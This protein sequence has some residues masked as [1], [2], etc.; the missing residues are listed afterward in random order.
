MLSSLRSRLWLSY[1]IVILMAVFGI[2]GPVLSSLSHS[3]LFY[4]QLV[5]HLRISQ[6]NLYTR[7][8]AENSLDMGRI[9]KII[10]DQ[11]R[12]DGFRYLLLGKDGKIIL[13]S[14]QGVFSPIPSFQTPIQET[15][16][17][18]IY[19]N[20]LTD[21]EHKPWMYVIQPIN[22]QLFFV[23]ASRQPVLEIRSLLRDEIVQP[24]V[25]GGIVALFFAF[26]LALFMSSWIGS[27]LRRLSDG[28]RQIE[29]GSYPV[30]EKEGPREIQKL[31]ESFNQMSR[32]VQQTEE[33]QK[34]FLANVSHEL[35]TP[36][37]SI[38][39]FAQSILDGAASTPQE[40]MQAASVI[41]DES[42][43][44]HRLVIDLLT[45]SRLEEGTVGMHTGPVN[46]SMIMDQLDEKL[47]PQIQSADLKIEK[48]IS[49]DLI[50][51]GDG[52][53]LAQV[54]TNL[55]DNAIKFTPSGG[56][57]SIELKQEQNTILACVSD[58]GVGIPD[59]E[60]ARIFE[61]FYQVDKSRRGGS[62]RG[63]GLGLAI[64]RQIVLSHNGE[65]WATSQPGKGSTFFVRLPL[66][67]DKST[68]KN[69]RI[70]SA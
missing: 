39:G 41:Y 3:P 46:L 55:L 42:S 58:T 31:A 67:A 70:T 13:D 2:F 1:T 44:M 24:M 18:P 5:L 22:D 38:Q 16:S 68:G 11:S 61:R 36:L 12:I 37:T 35:K 32:R 33:S 23:A 57:I 7:I 29:S 49:P 43:R 51:F 56:T 53:R 28:A 34:D 6:N 65:I 4:R 64:A 48:H 50:V 26:A 19:F 52:D 25:K 60:E 62:S 63:I 54:F 66:C 20:V 40:L 69:H 21:V 59:M 45:L 14:G 10:T 30:L 17:D 9:K 47:H 15:N 27:P 8:S